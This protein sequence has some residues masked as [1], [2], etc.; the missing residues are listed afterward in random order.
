MMECSFKPHIINNKKYNN[1]S[2]NILNL[3]SNPNSPNIFTTLYTDYK[4]RKQKSQT[5]QQNYLSSLTQ[6]PIIDDISQ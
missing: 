5:L 6:N 1:S 4:L 2:Q 3:S